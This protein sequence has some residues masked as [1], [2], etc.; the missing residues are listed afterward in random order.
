MKDKEV[1]AEDMIGTLICC[2]CAPH[3]N[4][5]SNLAKLWLWGQCL[6][7]DPFM[8]RDSS[9]N[10]FYYIVRTS[11]R[12]NETVTYILSRVFFWLQDNKMW[13]RD[14][15][16]SWTNYNKGVNSRVPDTYSHARFAQRSPP[17]FSN[18]T[19]QVLQAHSLR[20]GG[21]QLNWNGLFATSWI[22]A[23]IYS[24]T[25]TTVFIY[26]QKK[27]SVPKFSSRL[28]IEASV[29]NH[30]AEYNSSFSFVP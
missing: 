3:T 19:D 10:N 7:V 12:S 21:K 16:A 18:G 11:N 1:C 28:V 23:E 25:K 20:F 30:E 13:S 27:L 4:R 6:H 2:K 29:K 14:T 8:D 15:S 24:D 22:L 26:T 9:I 5:C 17:A